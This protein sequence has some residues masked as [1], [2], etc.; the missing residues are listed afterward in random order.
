[1]T[2]S[3]WPARLHLWFQL[4]PSHSLTSNI[5]CS[6]DIHT[7]IYHRE[8]QLIDYKDYKLH[9]SISISYW[10]LLRLCSQ[11]HW[12]CRPEKILMSVTQK[13]HSKME[14][15]L[16]LHGKSIWSNSFCFSQR[17]SIRNHT[18]FH[19][20]NRYTGTKTNCMQLDLDKHVSLRNTDF[21]QTDH[22]WAKR[23]INQSNA[24]SPTR[25]M[26]NLGNLLLLHTRTMECYIFSQ[27]H[28]LNL[29]HIFVLHVISV[30]LCDRRG[31]NRWYI[32]DIDTDHNSLFQF[33]HHIMTRWSQHGISYYCPFPAF[34][35]TKF[36]KPMWSVSWHSQLS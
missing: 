32:R 4:P 28:S 12:N 27:H 34:S 22:K 25:F 13:T 26:I 6:H 29:L 3:S 11:P 5:A 18:Q 8:W 19:W 24:S 7:T 9:L 15:I 17:D 14:F 2:F 33:S 31:L 35:W 10:I 30:Q 36:L 20:Y 16:N 23:P 21:I 1:M